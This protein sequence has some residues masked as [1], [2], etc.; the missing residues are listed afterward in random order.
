MHEQRG[1]R[2]IRD[3]TRSWKSAG[4]AALAVVAVVLVAL[5]LTR[6]GP[7]APV[8]ALAARSVALAS[9]VAAPL[10]FAAVGDSITNANSVDFAGLQVGDK[11]WV[12]YAAGPQLRFA[13]GWARGGAQTSTMARNAAPVSADVLVIIAGTNDT[14]RGVSFAT[15]SQNLVTIAQK[16]GAAR[17]IVSAIPPRDST[18]DVAV[19][20]NR[21]LALFATAHGW[22]F[23]D[24]MAGVRD[25]TVYADGMTRDGTHPS[26]SGA[27][28]IGA[29]LAEAI[30]R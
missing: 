30:T 22:T 15:T 11:S 19:E 7:Q 12:R 27:R 28:V 23:V 14:A 8:T 26:M 5:A 9:P 1:G 4:L 2:F 16:V 25:G 6:P 29:A 21:K 24:A 10:T 3:K 13:G 20:F 17:V 18:P